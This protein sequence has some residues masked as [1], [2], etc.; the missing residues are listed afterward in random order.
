M[1]AVTA[2]L[3]G[4]MRREVRAA[5]LVAV[6]VVAASALGGAGWGLLAP[7]ERLLVVEAG[8]GVG[9]T[10]ESTHQFDALA[11]F[12]LGGAVLGLLS[13]TAAWRWC[14]VRGPLLQIGLLIGSGA[15]AVVM[16]R[17]GEL[18]AESRHPI[19]HDPPVG[20]IIALPVEVGTA[21]ALI[22]QPLIASLVLLFLAALNTSDDL[23]TGRGLRMGE[24]F[25][26]AGALTPYADAVH[27]GEWPYRGYEPAADWY[28]LPESRPRH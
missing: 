28:S 19:P 2:P 4:G 3:P 10:G 21:L 18:V 20:Q 12:V 5:A 8:R 11:L 6:A 27:G 23:G 9:L 26:T 25:D 7:T 16:A 17:V 1:V 15:G 24:S 14:S 22:V 13:A